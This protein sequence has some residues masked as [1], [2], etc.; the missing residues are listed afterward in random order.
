MENFLDPAIIRKGMEAIKDEMKDVQRE[1][2]LIEA[3]MESR[4]QGLVAQK[5]AKKRNL[6]PSITEELET[7]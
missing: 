5:E 3:E 6:P 7:A 2:H 1:A 4:F